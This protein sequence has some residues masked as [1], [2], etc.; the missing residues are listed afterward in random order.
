MNWSL[1]KTCPGER[2]V[3]NDAPDRPQAVHREK[4]RE[5]FRKTYKLTED[6]VDILLES[7]AKSMSSTL[8][9]LYVAVGGDS[10]LEE[11]SR[12][13]HSMK[14]LLLN[15]GEQQWAE[16]ARELEKAAARGEKRDYGKM[17]RDI[18]QG[19]EDILLPG[20]IE[21]EW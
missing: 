3:N 6:Q 5:H 14:G 9:A 1:F 7:T 21:K 4:L 17:V 18:H 19:V 8:N 12:L 13:G 20:D 16:T 10:R 2:K 11:V 15:M